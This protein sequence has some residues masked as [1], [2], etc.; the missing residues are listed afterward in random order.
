M[1][2]EITLIYFFFDCKSSGLIAA[3][4]EI[5]QGGGEPHKIFML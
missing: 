5:V 4:V 1:K 3:T 2:P